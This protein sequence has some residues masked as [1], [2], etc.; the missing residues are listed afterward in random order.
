MPVGIGT[1]VSDGVGTAGV[2]VMING[3]NMTIQTLTAVGNKA[4]IAATGSLLNKTIGDTTN[5]S[6]GAVSSLD[7]TPVMVGT[8]VGDSA[9][10]TGVITS[11]SDTIVVVRTLALVGNKAGIATI[12]GTLSTE[13]GII[14]NITYSTITS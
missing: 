1:F 14:T 5:L 13:I 11:A 2:I 7:G 4:G 10:T 3:T 6:R 9:G 12:T 8:F